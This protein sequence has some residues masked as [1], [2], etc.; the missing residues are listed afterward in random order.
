MVEVHSQISDFRFQISA[1]I[2]LKQ[3][4]WSMGQ[5]IVPG[6]LDG[7]VEYL[8]RQ[9]QDICLPWL[10]E[11]QIKGRSGRGFRAGVQISMTG[12]ASQVHAFLSL[13]AH[14]PISVPAYL[15]D[16][17]LL[18]VNRAIGFSSCLTGLIGYALTSI[19]KCWWSWRGPQVR[20]VVFVFLL[21]FFPPSYWIASVPRNVDT[22]QGKYPN[23]NPR[24]QVQG[25]CNNLHALRLPHQA[26]HITIGV[27]L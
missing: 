8:G 15:S 24:F 3:V 6:L 13:P 10:E 16:Q 20:S 12:D 14:I 22:R 11:K 17:M 25:R 5:N 18:P 23:V 9:E 2:G 21:L 26:A 27:S 19:T 4:L 1:R 7:S